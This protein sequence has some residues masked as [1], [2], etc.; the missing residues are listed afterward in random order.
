MK[1]SN[2]KRFDVIKNELSE[3]LIFKENLDDLNKV[4]EMQSR[5]DTIPNSMLADR[6]DAT[7]FLFELQSNNAIVPDS[8]K[9][10]CKALRSTGL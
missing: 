3:Q 9:Q 6:F 10:K 7:D 8:F 1:M 2:K 4:S 5:I